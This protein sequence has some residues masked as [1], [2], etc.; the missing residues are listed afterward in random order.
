MKGELIRQRE[1]SGNSPRRGIAEHPRQKTPRTVRIAAAL[2][3]AALIAVAWQSPKIQAQT[4]T[5]EVSPETLSVEKGKT[6]TFKVKLTEQPQFDVYISPK[7]ETTGVTVSPP[8]M[9]F[10]TD[11]WHVYQTVTVTVAANATASTAAIKVEAYNIHNRTVTVTLTNPPPEY[12]HNITLG[13]SGNFRVTHDQ[14]ASFGVRLKGVPA[15][16]ATV[17]IAGES[18]QNCSTSVSTTSLTFN[19]SNWNAYQNVTLT[20][21]NKGSSDSER[22]QITFGGDDISNPGSLSVDVRKAIALTP[23]PTSLRMAEGTTKTFTVRLASEPKIVNL[24]GSR[25]VSFASSNP[26]VTITTPI[27]SGINRGK[28]LFNRQARYNVPQTVTLTAAAD[29]DSDHDSATISLSGWGLINKSVNVTVLEPIGLTLSPASLSVDEGEE[30]SFTVRLALEPDSDRTVNLTSSAAAVTLDTDPDESGDQ[31]A[32]TFTTVNWNTPQTVKVRAA[33]DDDHNDGSATIS[34]SGARIVSN[35]LAVTV[36]DPYE[37]SVDPASM[38]LVEGGSASFDVKLTAQPT[39]NI[40]V[41]LSSSNDDVGVFPNSIS[42]DSGNWNTARSIGVSTRQDTDWV[43]D[44][45]TITLEGTKVKTTEVAVTVREQIPLI[46]S[47]QSLE[48]NEG[49]STS[50]TVRL[51]GRPNQAESFSLE[52][53]PSGL[54]ISPATL[55]FTTTNWDSD[56]TVTVRAPSDGDSDD[57]SWT[58]NIKRGVNTISSLDVEVKEVIRMSVSK[59]ALNIQEGGSETLTVRLASQPRQPDLADLHRRRRRRLEH[60]P[61]R[62]AHRGHRLGHQR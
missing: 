50:F 20:A 24:H 23:N 22:C 48:V 12:E 62:D 60:P 26:D 17:T 59:S 34:L 6:G 5:V 43:R 55:S 28:M 39:G 36:R 58:L 35:T 31:S 16:D 25:T 27:D 11:N 57:E 38:S 49:T 29:S 61:D 13:Q 44:T 51:G 54:T 33:T 42:F 21:K 40:A 3:L 47:K 4:Y 14:P 30:G 2:A 41:S 10:K 46:L 19:S 52:S 37:L 8:Q 1:N 45:A 56:Q 18:K 7:S 9:T 32:L 15:G 53:S